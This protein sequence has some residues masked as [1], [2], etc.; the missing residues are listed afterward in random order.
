MKE[1]YRSPRDGNGHGTYVASAAAGSY[2]KNASFN[3]LAA[4]CARGG[5]PLARLAIYKACWGRTGFTNDASLLAAI[6][7]AIHDGVDVLNLSLGA[8]E[9]SWGLASL[10]AVLKGISVVYAAGNS[11]PFPQ[12]V[13]N[14]SPWVLTVAASSIDRSFPTAI[15]LGNNITIVVSI[16]AQYPDFSWVSL[17]YQ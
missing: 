6:D 4:G 11:G 9:D 17:A 10:H 16:S 12:T 14:T 2:V 13:S 3:G 1:D 8:P 15:T 5:A 7:D